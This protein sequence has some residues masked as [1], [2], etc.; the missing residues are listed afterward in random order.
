MLNR[1]RRAIEGMAG[2]FKETP[3]PEDH[4]LERLIL[5]HQSLK[6]RPL[7]R[8]CKKSITHK[9]T[10]KRPLQGFPFSCRDAILNVGA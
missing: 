9:K 6:S 2:A 3:I 4:A 1:K 10:L 7:S 5:E 8:S